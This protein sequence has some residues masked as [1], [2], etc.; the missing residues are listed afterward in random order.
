MN[1]KKWYKRNVRYQKIYLYQKY[2]G[3]IILSYERTDLVF[4]MKGYE[5]IGEFTSHQWRNI[6][7]YY[8]N[9]QQN[10]G[11]RDEEF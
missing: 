4:K 10:L 1:L 6:D 7:E 3:D 11:E 9:I 8:R 2:T 5:F